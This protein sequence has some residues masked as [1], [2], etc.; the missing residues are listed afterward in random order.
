M[1]S[2]VTTLIDSAKQYAREAIHETWPAAKEIAHP[3]AS[4]YEYDAILI[5]DE[6]CSIASVSIMHDPDADT[7]AL[8]ENA[9]PTT[10]PKNEGP[11]FNFE[12][13]HY[14]VPSYNNSWRQLQESNPYLA[15]LEARWRKAC[16]S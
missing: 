12:P 16:G 7:F 11:A 8:V 3:S 1:K 10:P 15:D 14:N 5:E 13:I 9:R 4:M 2:T 6:A